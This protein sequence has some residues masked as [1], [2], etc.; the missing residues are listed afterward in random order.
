MQIGALGRHRCDKND[1]I[2]PRYAKLVLVKELVTS[3]DTTKDHGSTSDPG[4]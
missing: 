1:R 3:P 4:F 2:V